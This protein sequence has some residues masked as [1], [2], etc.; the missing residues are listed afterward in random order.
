MSKIRFVL[1]RKYRLSVASSSVWQCAGILL[2]VIW[3]A[4]MLASCSSTAEDQLADHNFLHNSRVA[5][6]AGMD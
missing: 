1:S 4:F 5:H 3:F 6:L 2:V